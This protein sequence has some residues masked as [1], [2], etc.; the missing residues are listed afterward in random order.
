MARAAAGEI[1]LEIQM[2]LFKQSTRLQWSETLSSEWGMSLVQFLELAPKFFNQSFRTSSC[3][4]TPEIVGPP[5]FHTSVRD[6][7][8]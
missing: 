4:E 2:H 6:R 8:L 3:A 5:N 7:V 1:T